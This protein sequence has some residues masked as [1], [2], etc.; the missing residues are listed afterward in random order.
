MERGS[1]ASKFKDRVTPIQRHVDVFYERYGLEQ[2]PVTAQLFGQAGIEHNRLFGSTPLHYARI[3]LKNHR[4]AR[5]NPNAQ[6]QSHELANEEDILNAE[7]LYEQLTKPQC[8]PTSNGAAAVILASERFVR[9]HR[10]EAN[11]IE[12]LAMQMK[13]DQPNTFEPDV[14]MRQLVGYE[15][16]KKAAD[17]AYAESGLNP[18]HVQVIEL[19]DCFAPNELITYEALG[20]VGEGK[21]HELVD[22]GDNTY[23]GKWVVNPSGGLL[24]KG[25]PLGATGVAQCVELSW[26]LRGEAGAR[27]V[28]N[29]KIGLQHNIGMQMKRQFFIIIN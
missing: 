15:M 16:S 6:P 17:A 11:A 19:H 2:A 13:S 14:S 29:A 24:G 9:E 3:A 22:R 12:V 18:D 1:L 28:P 8:C 10:L 21:G 27:Q 5:N 20:L 23:G 4:N 26:Q 25:H 7:Q